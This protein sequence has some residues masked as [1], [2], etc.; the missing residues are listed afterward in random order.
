[1]SIQY[2]IMDDVGIYQIEIEHG[3]HGMILIDNKNDEILI[4]YLLDKK[5]IL[6][7]C[8]LKSRVF[9]IHSTFRGS[10]SL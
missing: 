4:S 7:N 2:V 3:K 9:F 10:S 6:M 8:P 5:V 1:M